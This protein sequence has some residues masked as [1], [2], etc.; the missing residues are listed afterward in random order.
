MQILVSCREAKISSLLCREAF[1][2]F[3]PVRASVYMVVASYSEVNCGGRG[4]ISRRAREG[5]KREV[6]LCVR[7]CSLSLVY[8][9]D[10]RR[11][12]DIGGRFRVYGALCRTPS[13]ARQFAAVFLESEQFQHL[14]FL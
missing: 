11:A 1:Q 7:R 14:P 10:V 13:P 12:L 4:G 3:S 5:V 8:G 9:Q 6:S 2:S